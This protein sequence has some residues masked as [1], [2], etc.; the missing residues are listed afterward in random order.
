MLYVTVHYPRIDLTETIGISAQNMIDNGIESLVQYLQ[1][2]HHIVDEFYILDV[3]MSDF[4]LN[5]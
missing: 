5:N 1:D 3:D 4:P 2:H